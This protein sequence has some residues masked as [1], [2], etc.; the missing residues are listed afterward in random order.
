MGVS[1]PLE[2]GP[3]PTK[4]IGVAYT[5]KALSLHVAMLIGASAKCPE[6]GRSLVLDD[7]NAIYLAPVLAATSSRSKVG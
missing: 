4:H 3:V 7:P 2:D 6:T 1:L 5:G